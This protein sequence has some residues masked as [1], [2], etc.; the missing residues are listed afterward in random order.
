MYKIC[1]FHM[2]VAVLFFQVI[3]CGWFD[4]LFCVTTQIIIISVYNNWADPKV[5]EP[6]YISIDIMMLVSSHVQPYILYNQFPHFIVFVFIVFSFASLWIF[7]L[8][9]VSNV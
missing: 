6:V 1:R 4:P 5:I 3:T 9:W 8:I 2:Y 7:Y